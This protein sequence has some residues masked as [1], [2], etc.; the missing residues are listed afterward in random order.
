MLGGETGHGDFGACDPAEPRNRRTRSSIVIEGDDGRRLLVD[1]GPEMRQQLLSCGI[2]RIDALF[3]THAHADHVAG[4]D[5]I[6]GLNRVADRPLPAFGTAQVLGELEGRFAYAFRPWSPPGF[7]RPVLLA[8]PVT[9]GPAEIEGMRF[10]LFEQVHGRSIT[11]GLRVGGF[12]YSTDV[13]QLDAPALR[14][15]QGVDTWVVGCFQRAP[16]PAHAHPELI[17]DWAR[18]LGVRRT[19]LTHM[20]TDLDWAWMASNLQSGL[21]PAYDGMQIDL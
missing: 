18:Q 17:V 4:L 3:Y 16:H 12:A 10:S 7:Y 15:L 5:D 11:I 2:G 19:I 9:P 1:T 6:R 13:M 8:H 21:E 20:G 14:C